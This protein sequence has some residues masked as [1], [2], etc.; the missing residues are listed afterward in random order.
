LLKAGIL[1]VADIF[2]VNKADHPAAL[3]LQREIRSM[4]EM[5]DHSRPA[6]ALVA[7]QA[8]DGKGVDE[9][10]TALAEHERAIRAGGEL[11]RRRRHAFAHRVRL[12]ALGAI[13]ARL[14][15][16][17]DDLLEGAIEATD[18]AYRAAELLKARVLRAEP[19]PERSSMT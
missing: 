6:P 5:L 14:E 7:T 13:E 10:W 18:D 12:L 9:L 17:I 3:Q 15:H 2:V 19:P 8:S 16:E 11:A 4:M 1:E